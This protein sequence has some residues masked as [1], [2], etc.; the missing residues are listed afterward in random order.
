MQCQFQFQFKNALFQL[1]LSRE[2][3]IM[4]NERGPIYKWC[5]LLRLLSLQMTQF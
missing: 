1:F 5:S 2:T 4:N 3:F